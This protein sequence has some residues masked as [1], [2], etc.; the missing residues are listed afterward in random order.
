MVLKFK[1]GPQR[2][3]IAYEDFIMLISG[4]PASGKTQLAE[5]IILAFLG[6][7]TDYFEFEDLPKNAKILRVDTEMPT[8]L[9]EASKKRLKDIAGKV[10][11]SKYIDMKTSHI[12]PNL[13]RIEH[14]RDLMDSDKDIKVL[15]IDNLTGVVS[16]VMKDDEAAYITA[17]LDKLAK[18][19]GILVICLCHAASDGSP[20][21]FIGK[22]MD[23]QSSM[24]LGLEIDL[25]DSTTYVT[26][27]KSRADKINNFSFTLSPNKQVVGGVYMPFP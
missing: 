27:F 15:I 26:V 22:T 14:I 21:G 12:V 4:K 3:E 24:S 13:S 1:D 17:Y 19:R 2:A 5:S 18:E 9:L 20:L 10:V 16:S 11:D 7:N 23:R 6:V 8:K 25:N